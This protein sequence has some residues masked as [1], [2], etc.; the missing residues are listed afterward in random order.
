M[1]KENEENLNKNTLQQYCY[2]IEL[3]QHIYLALYKFFKEWFHLHLLPVS[4]VSW[5][6]QIKNLYGN[7][8]LCYGTQD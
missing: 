4:T 1:N 2:S 7:Q 6:Q 8:S 5:K 3:R